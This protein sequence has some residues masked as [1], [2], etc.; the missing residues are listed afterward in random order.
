MDKPIEQILKNKDKDKIPEAIK[1]L[2]KNNILTIGML[3]QLT[4]DQI[5]Q[6]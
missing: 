3:S 1:V 6:K 2:K 5:N 4:V